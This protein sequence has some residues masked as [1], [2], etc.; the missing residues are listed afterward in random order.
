MHV[1]VLRVPFGTCRAIDYGK[2]KN[3]DMGR[4]CQFDEGANRR[5]FDEAATDQLPLRPKTT[6]LAGESLGKGVRLQG[7]GKREGG[8]YGAQRKNGTRGDNGKWNNGN[9]GSNGNACACCAKQSHNKAECRHV[10]KEAIIVGRRGTSQRRPG[11]RQRRWMWGRERQLLRIKTIQTAPAPRP[12][13][14]HGY[15]AGAT[16]MWR[17]GT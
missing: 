6:N 3:D 12:H 8:S 15:A 14:I 9:H 16:I 7:E 4:C 17:T 2:N 13:R 11:A 1:D 5:K 10:G